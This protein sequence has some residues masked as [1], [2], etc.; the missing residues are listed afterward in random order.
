MPHQEHRRLLRWAITGG[1]LV[2]FS[3]GVITALT[4]LAMQA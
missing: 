1:L 2:G 4:W 3:A